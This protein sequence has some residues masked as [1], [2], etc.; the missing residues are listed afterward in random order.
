VIS[1]L[2]KPAPS[3]KYDYYSESARSLTKI[4]PY[5]GLARYTGRKAVDDFGHNLLRS[6]SPQQKLSGSSASISPYCAIV[7]CLWDEI[8]PVGNRTP[9]HWVNTGYVQ[10][11]QVESILCLPVR[12]ML[13]NLSSQSAAIRIAGYLRAVA[14]EIPTPTWTSSQPIG[15]NFCER[16]TEL[17]LKGLI[18]GWAHERGLMERL[19]STL[20]I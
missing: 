3:I 15:M 20:S 5:I 14:E 11:G 17:M 13:P 9:T 7:D 12:L 6:I 2:T 10:D 19:R 4:K 18:T 16:Y 1:T 8:L